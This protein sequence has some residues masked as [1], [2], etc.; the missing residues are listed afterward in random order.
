MGAKE[1]GWLLDA[2]DNT[3]LIVEDEDGDW[4]LYALQDRG[5]P[6][7]YRVYHH[8]DDTWVSQLTLFLVCAWC[9]VEAPQVMK[10]FK[11]LIEWE[12]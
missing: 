1:K 6:D 5:W 7:L 4:R 11:N 2:E 10:G 8:H 9:R 12:R 3:T